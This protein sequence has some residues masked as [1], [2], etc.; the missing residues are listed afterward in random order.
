V[1]DIG[2]CGGLGI[3]RRLAV[4]VTIDASA[5]EQ[6]TARLAA[7]TAEIDAHN[8]GDQRRAVIGAPAPHG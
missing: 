4:R 2:A 7:T 6:I 3:A 8:P 5:Q 1:V